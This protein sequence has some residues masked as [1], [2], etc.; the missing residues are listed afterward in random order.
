LGDALLELAFLAL[1]RHPGIFKE[2]LF[3]CDQTG[4]L[5]IA[6]LREQLGRELDPLDVG[7]LGFLA[8]TPGRIFA[9]ALDDDRKVRLGLRLIETD[10]NL[11][12][13]DARSVA[14]AQLA[15]DAAGR[16]L[17]FL[18]IAVDNEL[19]LSDHSTGELSGR[20]P[21]ADASH[22]QRDRRAA[23]QQVVA[24]RTMRDR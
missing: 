13:L 20:G 8:R 5:G 2:L 22:Q 16:M 11:A 9:Q 23:G 14:Y 15:N 21:A 18:N 1:P 12:C 19:T 4:N 7:D 3:A 6:A 24:Y 17:D 10:D